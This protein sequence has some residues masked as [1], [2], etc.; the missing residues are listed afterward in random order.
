MQAFKRDSHL[1]NGVKW[2]LAHGFLAD[3][4]GIHLTSPDFEMG[5]PI[6]A[7]QLHYLVLHD[8]LEFPDMESMNIDERSTS[9]ILSR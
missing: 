4:G 3:M 1:C 9:D 2:T 6:T 7:A 8:H 5:F